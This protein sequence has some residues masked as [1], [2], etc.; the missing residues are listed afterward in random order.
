MGKSSQGIPW[1]EAVAAVFTAQFPHL[2]DNKVVP[3]SC[4]WLIEASNISCTAKF[5]SSPIIQTLTLNR[6][7][8]KYFQRLTKASTSSS[9]SWSSLPMGEKLDKKNG[10]LTEIVRTQSAHL[11]GYNAALSS[12]LR[13]GPVCGQAAPFRQKASARVGPCC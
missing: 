7:V 10:S 11:T 4:A 3:I 9:S 5:M 2:I 1:V 13:D 8:R 12:S 6:P